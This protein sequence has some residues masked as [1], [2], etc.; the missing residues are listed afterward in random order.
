MA[1]PKVILQVYP[2]MP[3]DG[4]EGRKAARPI[5]RDGPL[6]NKIIHEWT[7][8]LKAAE[9]LGVWGAATIEH[10][11]H[12]E[13]YELGPNPGALNAYWAAKLDKMHVG[14]MGYVMATQDPIRVAEETAIIDH[15]SNGR[16]FVGFARGYQSRWANILGQFTESVATVSDG[17]SADQKNREIFE[18]RVQMVIDCWTKDSLQ[19]SGQYYQAPYPLETGVEGYPAWKIARDAGCEGEIDGNGAVQAISVVP[20]PY[21]RPYPPVFVA[22][23]KSEESIRYC[24][25]MGF[26][27]LHF[28]AF[29]K[30]VRGNEI[31]IEEAKKVGKTYRT[32]ERQNIVRWVHICE[33]EQEYN[34]KLRDYDLD[35]YKNF[36]G[37]FFPQFPTGDVDDD[38]MI[39]NIKKSGI[40]IGGTV[41]QVRNEWIDIYNKVPCEYITLIFHF[42]QQPK[43]D[44]IN[45]IS[46]FMT[47][48]WPHL[49][50]DDSLVEP[51]VRDLVD[52]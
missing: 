49:E 51:P 39:E 4:E 45:T 10:H 48:V 36:Y 33:S 32:G 38:E 44:C 12:S 15:L 26:Y 27:P 18:E 19:L 28:T 20:S 1:R 9:A 46:R 37:P 41:D 50:Y 47:E 34:R 23:S 17:S 2:V 52:A 24:A 3:T 11:L 13:G 6:Y 8:V 5:G 31:Y 43:E 25:R 7:D 40:Y 30:V 29:D 42:A 22:T 21:Q 14:A 16:F 35:I